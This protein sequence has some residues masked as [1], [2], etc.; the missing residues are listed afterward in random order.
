MVT[1]AG[2]IAAT[3]KELTTTVVEATPVQPEASVTVTE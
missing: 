2:L 3:G 1:A